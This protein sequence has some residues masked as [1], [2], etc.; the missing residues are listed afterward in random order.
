MED[1]Y[2]IFFKVIKFSLYDVT[3]CTLLYKV[4]KEINKWCKCW[5]SENVDRS[6]QEKIQVTKITLNN[7]KL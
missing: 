7:I 5:K 2:K 4:K 6:E 3:V 1:K